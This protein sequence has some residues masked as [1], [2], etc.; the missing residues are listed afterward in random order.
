MRIKPASLEGV[1]A[2]RPAR[3]VGIS[4]RQTATAAGRMNGA[5]W[6]LAA[7][8]LALAA[9][10]LWAELRLENFGATGPGRALLLLGKLFAAAAIGLLVT[11]VS[12]R[13]D[14]PLKPAMEHAQILLCVAGAMMMMLIGDSLARAFG[15]VGAASMVR[16]RTPVKDPKAVTVLFLLLGLGMAAGLGAFLL[17]GLGAVFLCVFLIAMGR[18]APPPAQMLAVTLPP[19][20]PVSEMEQMLAELG[21]RVEPREVS[22]RDGEMVL[23]YLVTFDSD[24]SPTS[25]TAALLGDGG[26]AAVRAVGWEPVKAG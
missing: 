26:G 18:A 19:E 8:G 17:A 2:A 5:A 1:A 21:I 4:V 11:G 3:S 15:I 23:R 12:R 13:V 10:A 22:R 14:K 20:T 7:G 24:A 25:V 9:A 6:A 16:F